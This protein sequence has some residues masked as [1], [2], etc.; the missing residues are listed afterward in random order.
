M[1]YPKSQIQTN[2]YTRGNE[3]TLN[4][5]PY[6]GPYYKLS[7]NRMFSGKTPNDPLTE[8]ITPIIIQEESAPEVITSEWVIEDQGYNVFTTASQAG[9][10]P[11]METPR[12]SSSDIERGSFMRYFVKSINSNSYY[13]T[14]KDA[15]NN[16]QNRNPNIQYSL[17]QPIQLSWQLVGDRTEVYNRNIETVRLTSQRNNLPGF[18]SFF[19]GDF[20]R[21]FVPEPIS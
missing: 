16:I 4:G 12:P 9:L 14:N 21:Y 1:P 10:P 15:H 13:E 6:N 11:P 8:E 2:L 19:K 7:S 20:A 17:Y 5:Q 18:G 3:F